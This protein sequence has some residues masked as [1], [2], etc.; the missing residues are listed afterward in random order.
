[1]KVVEKADPDSNNITITMVDKLGGEGRYDTQLL[2]GFENRPVTRA[3]TIYRNMVRK[4]VT[5][6]GYGPDD[7]DAKP[8]NLYEFWIDQLAN[9][10]KEHYGRSIRQAILEQFGETLVHGRTAALHVRNWHPNLAIGLRYYLETYLVRLDFGIS[11]EILGI[12]FNF[13]HIF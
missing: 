12:Y 8:Y 7:L 1:M 5:T 13:N 4:A 3:F 6:P 2:I 10:N 9:W 11:R